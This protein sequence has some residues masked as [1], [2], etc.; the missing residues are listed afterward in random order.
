MIATWRKDIRSLPEIMALSTLT[1]EDTPEVEEMETAEPEPKEL[2]HD[3]IEEFDI[4]EPPTEGE[5]QEIS[6][7]GDDTVAEVQDA[8]EREEAIGEESE[9]ESPS[10]DEDTNEESEATSDPNE[11]SEEE[12][13]APER[14]EAIGEES[15]A[16]SEPEEDNDEA[17]ESDYEEEGDEDEEYYEQEEDEDEEYGQPNH[18]QAF[19]LEAARKRRLANTFATLISKVAED[20]SSTPV[21]GD[22]MWD[23]EALLRRRITKTPLDKCRLSY[24]CEK[25]VLV[26]DTSGSCYEQAYFYADIAKAASS[27]G[28]V[29]IYDAPNA[30]TRRKFVGKEWERDNTAWWRL[31]GR[32][33]LFFGDFD[34]GDAPVIASR[35]NK[36]FWFS[37]ESRY[38]DMNKHNWCRF[39]LAD[40][41]G[42]YYECL[43]EEDFLSKAKK[44][45]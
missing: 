11:D 22:D 44:I 19:G 32:T 24:E 31:K 35:Q 13:D 7:G 34:G 40:F 27:R 45:R 26:L 20:L 38:S 5:D 43:R 33:I 28:D 10:P 21:F 12:E 3:K 42:K 18:E 9:D 30:V 41:K 23:I 37:C 29:E 8:P 25:V 16:M 15:E 6:H 1:E 14:E 39:V 2:S 36:V 17:E 4:V